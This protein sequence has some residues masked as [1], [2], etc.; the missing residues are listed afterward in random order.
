MPLEADEKLT[1]TCAHNRSAD[2]AVVRAPGSRSKVPGF[3]SLQKRRENFLLHGQ[4]SVL[5]VVSVSIPPPSV[6]LQ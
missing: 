4:L 6:L 5:T 3:E 2:S 1:I